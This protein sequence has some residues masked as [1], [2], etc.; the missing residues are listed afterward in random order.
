MFTRFVKKETFIDYQGCFGKHQESNDPEGF[1][2]PSGSEILIIGCRLDDSCFSGVA[3]IAMWNDT[4]FS[5]DSEALT[6][7]VK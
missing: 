2:L 6:Y 1:Y 5:I 3:V 4:V 7:L